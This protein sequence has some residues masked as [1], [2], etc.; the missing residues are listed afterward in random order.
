[1][2]DDLGHAMRLAG[3]IVSGKSLK[4]YTMGSYR[5]A[6]DL[7]RGRR[8]ELDAVA[9]ALLSNET[10]GYDEVKILFDATAVLAK[11]GRLG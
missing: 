9:T 10:M 5:D 2:D 1:M 7:V 3:R 6:L 8:A 4:T 11:V